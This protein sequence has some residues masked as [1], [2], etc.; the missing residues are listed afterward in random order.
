V[1]D[2]VEGCGDTC[3]SPPPPPPPVEQPVA[4][5]WNTLTIQEN[6]DD[7]GLAIQLIDEEQVYEAMSFKEGEAQE[8][9]RNKVPIPVIT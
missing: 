4:V 8:A 9:A 5:D 1:P 6:P 3:S 2:D 7:D